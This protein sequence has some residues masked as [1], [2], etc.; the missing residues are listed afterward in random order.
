MLTKMRPTTTGTVMTR[1]LA[2]KHCQGQG[3]HHFASGV[4]TADS[5]E[6]NI[7]ENSG[8]YVFILHMYLP[9]DAFRRHAHDVPHRFSAAHVV[10]PSTSV[11]PGRGWDGVLTF[12]SSY[13]P[14]YWLLLHI[15]CPAAFT[16]QA[17][18]MLDA[19]HI[20]LLLCPHIIYSMCCNHGVGGMGLAVW[21]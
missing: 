5:V 19:S 1:S 6:L 3:L 12:I 17:K 21:S 8:E 15:V 16:H 9:H 7:C 13:T 18:H 10:R 11:W 4:K 2:A 14:M 20:V